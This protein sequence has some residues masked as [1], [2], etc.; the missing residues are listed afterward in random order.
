MKP[1]KPDNQAQNG[2]QIQLMKVCKGGVTVEVEA[3]Y[4]TAE[5]WSERTHIPLKVV[6]EALYNGQL[7]RYQFTPKGRLY[8]NVVA[9]TE[10][11]L[12]SNPW[13]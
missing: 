5:E 8:V 13:N 6:K 7:A 10:R 9:E 3:P 4:C 2:K 12:A 1:T 11:L